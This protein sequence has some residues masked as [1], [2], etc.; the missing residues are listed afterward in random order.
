VSQCSCMQ[1]STMCLSVLACKPTTL[2]LSVLACKPAPCV[3]VFWHASQQPCVSVFL[4]ASQHHVSQC[5]GMQANNPVSQC[6]CMQASTMCLSVLACK[7]TTLCLSVLACKPTPCVFMQYT[8][9]MPNLLGYGMQGLSSSYAQE[10]NAFAC[11]TLTYGSFRCKHWTDV[12]SVLHGKIT[13]IRFLLARTPIHHTGMTKATRSPEMPFKL[14]KRNAVSSN[15]VR[16]GVP[17]FVACGDDTQ[18]TEHSS[19]QSIVV[20]HLATNVAEERDHTTEF[21]RIEKSDRHH[22]AGW[23]TS[24]SGS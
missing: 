16:D 13:W 3:S 10:K 20:V 11:A 12:K 24:L 22:T 7:P 21:K 2:C 15:I 14:Y 18:A 9:A 8:T 1:A 19:L 23:Q 4:H 17:S 5:S 6:S